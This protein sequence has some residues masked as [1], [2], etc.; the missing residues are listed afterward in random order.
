MTPIDIAEAAIRR[1]AESHPRPPQVTQSQAA[2]MLHVSRPT[3]SRMI[4]AGTLR[5]NNCGMIPVSE[6]DRALAAKAG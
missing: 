4:R 5:L 1:Y 2:E 3:V 6:I